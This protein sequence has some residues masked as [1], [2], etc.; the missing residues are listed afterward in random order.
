MSAE[1]LTSKFWFWEVSPADVRTIRKCE[2]YFFAVCWPIAGLAIPWT[3]LWSYLYWHS[4]PIQSMP[5]WL[6]GIIA[7]TPGTLWS[8]CFGGALF[9]SQF[10]HKYVYSALLGGVIAVFPMEL[11]NLFYNHLLSA[12]GRTAMQQFLLGPK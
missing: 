7:R 11:L 1:Q 3:L 10:R 4:L 9:A 12:G 6:A 2:H 8:G 5:G